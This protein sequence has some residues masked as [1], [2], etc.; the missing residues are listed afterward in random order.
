[1]ESLKDELI[2]PTVVNRVNAAFALVAQ[3]M[4]ADDRT[5]E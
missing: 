2:S 4:E 5:N 3:S 1:M